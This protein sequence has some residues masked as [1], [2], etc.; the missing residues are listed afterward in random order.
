MTTTI[1]PHSHVLYT[2]YTPFERVFSIDPDYVTY[3]TVHTVRLSAEGELFSYSIGD[4]KYTVTQRDKS[5]R[6]WH[7][8]SAIPSLGNSFPRQNCLPAT[9]ATPPRLP[10]ST[11]QPVVVVVANDD[12]IPPPSHV[13]YTYYTLFERVFFV[14]SDYVS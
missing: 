11:A 13:I 3:N 6:A 10:V 9:S 5:V 1:P 7:S 12:D 14:D 4:K 8:A 2:Y